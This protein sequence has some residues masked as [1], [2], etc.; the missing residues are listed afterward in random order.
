MNRREI[1]NMYKNLSGSNSF[2][3]IKFPRGTKLHWQFAF[4]SL[5]PIMRNNMNIDNF[6]RYIPRVPLIGYNIVHREG[7]IIKKKEESQY[8]INVE[9]K[10]FLIKNNEGTFKIKN[11]NAEEKFK[12]MLN[13]I[14][15]YAKFN[16]NKLVMTITRTDGT[17]MGY[18][19]T[20]DNIRKIRRIYGNQIG[21]KMENITPSD[22]EIVEFLVSG[23]IT[24]VKIH[25]IPI[26]IANRAL[27][28]GFFRY[29]HK[30]NY[31][32]TRYGIYNEE[33]IKGKNLGKILQENC[34][35]QCLNNSGIMTDEEI[36]NAKFI[37]NSRNITIKTIKLIA[38]D[39]KININIFT[40]DRH[41]TKKY[42]SESLRK[43]NIGLIDEHYFL[44]EKICLFTYA[45][46][47]YDSVKDFKDWHKIEKYSK[48][49]GK[50]EKSN[51][52]SMDSIFLVKYLVENKDRFLT[53]ITFSD[54]VD[55]STYYNKIKNFGNLEYS[56]RCSYLIDI[57]EEKRYVKNLEEYATCKRHKDERGERIEEL[58]KIIKQYED[59]H[60]KR[61]NLK[62]HIK[63]YDLDNI[64]HLDFET[65]VSDKHVAYMLC[66]KRSSE[67]D[68]MENKN[69]WFFGEECGLYFLKELKK[70]CICVAH[71]LGYDFRFLFK[72]LVVKRIIPKG[73]RIMEA[74]C[75]FYNIERN[76]KINILFKDSY[77]LIPVAL[78]EFPKIFGFENIVKEAMPYSI[79]TKE[80]LS[81]KFM[82]IEEAKSIFGDERDNKLTKSER[83]YIRRIKIQ[84]EK[85]IR[86]WDLVD[87]DNEKQY[88]HIK[89]S[90]KYCDIDVE[91][92]KR[93][94]NAFSKSIEKITGLDINNITS[95]PSIADQFLIKEGCY[96]GTHKFSGVV[97]EFISNA[98]VGGRTMTRNNKKYHIIYE[99]DKN[100][101]LKYE[102][103]VDEKGNITVV[104]NS[105]IDDFDAVGLYSSALYRLNGF[106]KG[107]PKI[108]KSK[109]YNEIK[110]YDGYII[111]IKINKV[112]K[113]RE[114]PLISVKDGNGI[115]NFINNI[116]SENI[117][118]DKVTLEDIIEFHELEEDD[119][120]IIKGYYF[121]E[122][123][124]VKIKEII[125]KLFEERLKE[126]KLPGGGMQEVYK[127]IMNASYGKTIM[128]PIETTDK[129]FQD[130]R[131]KLDKEIKDFEKNNDLQDENKKREFEE[132]KKKN[133]YSDLDR[134]VIKNY[135]NIEFYSKVGGSDKNIIRVRNPINDHYSRP[136]IGNQI[137]SMSK[138]IMNEVMCL[139]EDLGIKIFYQDTDSMHIVK[140]Q[141]EL[142]GDKFREKYGRELIGK[143]MGQFHCDFNAQ[144][145]LYDIKINSKIEPTSWESYFL[146]KKT[147]IDKLRVHFTDE[148]ES[149][150][151]HIR[152]KGI[153]TRSVR[154]FG[155]N[156]MSTYHR[157]FEGEKLEF[158]LL[159]GS[160]IKFEFK[161]D[162]SIWSKSKFTREVEF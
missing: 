56:N 15:T 161:K 57:V 101:D 159:S 144:K 73:N 74:D 39:L 7:I 72:Y 36:N 125:K 139:A 68:S 6:K 141:V 37:I 48:K 12:I 53:Q 149:F 105:V 115:R 22:Y 89:Y 46:N 94:Y 20:H 11:V 142:L 38:E 117:I 69:K 25:Y 84:F 111:E 112:N 16:N 127:L 55:Y 50:Y 153:P 51:N 114:F 31:D 28:G 24:L 138:R 75:D 87:K 26:A 113:N 106:L 123:M 8:H 152:M 86:D 118:V 147:Y 13:N 129:I 58:K 124:N 60:G 150:S 83:E 17:Q 40:S 91:I 154:D 47:N 61:L 93:G 18:T 107:K 2:N 33:K 95:L 119:Y 44:K 103:R 109:K 78:K 98:I 151:Y 79:Y 35:I 49:K 1:Y 81:K 80:N 156:I 104:M 137:L 122:G 135:N 62:H 10:I 99:K 70:D 63:K 162:Y 134:Y 108:L 97:R 96:D 65:D 121:D 27:N 14:Q 77:S 133:K 42:C 126:K 128:K 116:S 52:K 32:L 102:E 67:E 64:V 155:E 3:G 76:M 132:I 21:W 88:D 100:S 45:L 160:Q 19:F 145:D 9:L 34:F 90:K 136:H 130:N 148:E 158:D 30:L 54:D 110:D 5:A 120:E 143:N 41:M 4:E 43:I 66:F 59:V 82:S 29:F 157:L 71:N 146:G 23:N 85:N 140:S 92:L 131:Y